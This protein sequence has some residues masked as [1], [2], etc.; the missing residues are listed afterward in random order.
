M[1][2]RSKAENNP[3]IAAITRI[4]GV[5]PLS[6]ASD[7]MI[8]SPAMRRA[9]GIILSEFQREAEPEDL[10]ER[11]YWVM[12]TVLLRETQRTDNE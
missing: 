6:G 12:R 10:A 2:A 4:A 8:V 5:E 1:A 11:V 3:Q 9:G 7:E